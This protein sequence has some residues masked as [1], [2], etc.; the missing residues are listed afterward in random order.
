MTSWRWSIRSA[1]G[2]E[3]SRSDAFVSRDEAE[4]W[5]AAE[6]ERLLADGGAS[7]ALLDDGELAYEMGLDS[8]D[9]GSEER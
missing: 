4:T 2:D 8:A 7:V 9:A 3:T 1:S 6:W 5:I